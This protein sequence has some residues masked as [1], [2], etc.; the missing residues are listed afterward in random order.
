VR[1]VLLPR[2][3]SLRQAQ[4]AVTKQIFSKRVRGATESWTQLLT[5]AA[6]PEW[7]LDG[8]MEVEVIK[9]SK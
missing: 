6:D 7:D 1:E 9:E 4:K 2:K 5:L 8:F 3:P